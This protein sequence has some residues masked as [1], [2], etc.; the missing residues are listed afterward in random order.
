MDI[1]TQIAI[2][3]LKVTQDKEANDNFPN[4]D[5]WNDLEAKINNLEAYGQPNDPEI[6]YDQD[7]YRTGY[8]LNNGNEIHESGMSVNDE[9][10]H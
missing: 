6:M 3:T 10:Q 4:G 8:K 5:L 7:G 2:D 1:F 9:S